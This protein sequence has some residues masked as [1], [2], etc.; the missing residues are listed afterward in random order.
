MKKKRKN[1]DN[2]I[3]D[4]FLNFFSLIVFFLLLTVARYLF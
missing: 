3:P 4:Q 1:A 2:K